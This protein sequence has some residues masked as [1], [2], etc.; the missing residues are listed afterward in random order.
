[1][2]PVMTRYRVLAVLLG[3]AALASCEKNAV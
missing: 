3:T 2:N 1:M